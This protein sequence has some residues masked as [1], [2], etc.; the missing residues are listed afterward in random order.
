M[1]PW[2]SL[3]ATL[4][5]GGAL[6]GRSAGT[7][8]CM[9]RGP[10][11]WLKGLSCSTILGVLC[12]RLWSKAWCGPSDLRPSHHVSTPPQ[13]FAILCMPGRCQRHSATHTR[14]SVSHIEYLH[15]AMVVATLPLAP[16]STGSA[17]MRRSAIEREDE[18]ALALLM[19][20][21]FELRRQVFGNAALGEAN[22][23]MVKCA[24]S[25]NGRALHSIVVRSKACCK[26]S[27]AASVKVPRHGRTQHDIERHSCV[28]LADTQQSKAAPPLQSCYG[29]LL[30]LA[31]AA[32]FTGSGGAIVA[33]CP[34]GEP[35]E[36]ALKAAC[37]REGFVCVP[38][39]V[40]CP[41]HPPS[42]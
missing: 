24:W 2:R 14:T 31:A 19:N 37:E 15:K 7:D 8:H 16:Q 20:K 35:Q 9:A 32:K 29:P 21:N 1:M 33:L 3:P 22:L 36:A 12:M 30:M 10:A 38:V 18:L 6:Q 27:T 13:A 17:D 39:Q 42:P 5:K 28:M 4:R 34:E 40:C 41:H 25:V 11:H 23:A 26:A